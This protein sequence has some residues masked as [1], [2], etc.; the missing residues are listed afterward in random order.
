[1]TRAQQERGLTHAGLKL[2]WRPDHGDGFNWPESNLRPK[3]DAGF[4]PQRD[5]TDQPR[6]YGAAE[7][8]MAT[9]TSGAGQHAGTQGST[10]RCGDLVAFNDLSF[11]VAEGWMFGFVGSNGAARP[12]PCACS[13]CWRPMPASSAGAD[14][15]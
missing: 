9:R 6:C 11:T 7:G 12:P 8:L 2:P 1:M 3:E 10:G 13:E 14:K 5:G 4:L 15:I